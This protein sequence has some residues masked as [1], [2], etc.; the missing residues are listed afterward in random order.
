MGGRWAHPC[1]S[2]TICLL[3]LMLPLPRN[4]FVRQLS[5]PAISMTL[6]DPTLD[7]CEAL[8]RGE[9]FA[10]ETYNKAIYR[11]ADSPHEDLLERIRATHERNANKLRWL[12]LEHGGE[13][14]AA[15][16]FWKGLAQTLEGA[17]IIALDYTV[18]KLLKE[19]EEH[20]VREYRDALA[21]HD[22]S[23][24]T[25]EIVCKELLPPLIDHLVELR[26]GLVPSRARTPELVV[27]GLAW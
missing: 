2:A 7:T 13:P 24:E 11:F 9:I 8:Y 3:I 27:S 25:K 17:A 26:R 4:S 21:D 19:G 14:S 18:L 5:P 6:S 1:I 12:I 15:S 23:E 10:V 22:V 16:V 20:G